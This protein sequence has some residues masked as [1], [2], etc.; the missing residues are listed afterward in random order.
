MAEPADSLKGVTPEQYYGIRCETEEQDGPNYYMALEDAD[1]FRRLKQAKEIWKRF[2]EDENSK[3]ITPNPILDEL[4][5]V[6]G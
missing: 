3:F 1:A 6:L 2:K 5:E 4:N